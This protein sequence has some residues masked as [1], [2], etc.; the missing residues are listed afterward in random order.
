MFIDVYL[1]FVVISSLLENFILFSQQPWQ[2][3]NNMMYVL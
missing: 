2:L 3:D 1:S